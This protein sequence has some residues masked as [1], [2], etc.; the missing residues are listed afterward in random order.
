[1]TLRRWG[2]RCLLVLVVLILS[3]S[4]WGLVRAGLLARVTHHPGSLTYSAPFMAQQR[5]RVVPQT[6]ST[7]WYFAEGYT[8][9]NFT[10]YLVLA[11]FNAVSASVT[12]KYL[13]G[14]GG[15]ITKN[16]TVPQTARLTLTVNTEA[17]SGQNVSMVITSTQPIV[18]ERPMYFTY[19]G[20][21]GYTIPGGTDILGAT[22]LGTSYDFGYL[23]VTTGHDTWLTILNN[24]A[25]SLTATMQY[26]PASGGTPITRTHMVTATSRGTVQVGSE[27]L[28]AGTYAALVTLSQPGM[29]ERVLYLQ[30]ANTGYTGATDVVGVTA[31]QTSWYFAEGYTNPASSERYFLFNP[32][33]TTPAVATVTFYR[34]DGSTALTQLVLAAG[35][36]AI[37]WANAVL[38]MGNVNNGAQVQATAPFSP[39]AS[40]VCNTVARWESTATPPSLAPPMCWARR[41]QDSPSILPKATPVASLLNG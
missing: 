23:D 32:S 41:P 24:N 8:G 7:S 35:Q 26:F 36:Q 38:G 9:T 12:V 30:D 20:M 25:T 10:E 27:G 18:A 6:V 5:S 34:A 1:M 19:T 22:Q 13:L 16:Y 39:N 4:A 21:S 2:V 28:A 14:S 11:N 31:P 33:T 40:P 37:L 29:V 3:C 17:G 15:P